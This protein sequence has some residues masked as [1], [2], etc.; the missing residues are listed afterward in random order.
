MAHRVV[1]IGGG[2][3][4]LY[5]AKALKRADVELTLIDQRN[6]H[7]F[8]PLL[9]QVA[10]GELSP[11]DVAFPLRAVLSNQRNAR[12]LMSKVVGL[13]AQ[14]RNVTLSDGESVSYDSLI[15]AT[16]AK[17]HYFGNDAWATFAPGLKSIEDATG[18]RHRI[19]YA[20]E[21]AEKEPDPEKRRA[22][23]TFV[24]VGAGP[25]GV[26]LAGALGEIAN[27]TLKGDFRSIR[28]EEARILLLDGSP[29]VLTPF[30]PELS[31]KAERSLIR[32]GVRTMLNVKVVGV[33]RNGVEL[34]GARGTHRIESRTVL[35]AAGVTAAGFTKIIAEETGVQLDRG[36]RV[37]VD[38]HCNVPGHPEIFVIGDAA[39]FKGKDG[40][41]LPGV[42]PTAMQQGSYA[43]KSIKLRLRGETIGAFKYFDK[44]S[45]AVIG[46]ARGV[47]QFG[48]SL[49][50]SGI[51]AWLLWL[52]VHLMY[53]VTFQNRLVV[54]I[55]WGFNYTTYNRGARLITGDADPEDQIEAVKQ[56]EHAEVRNS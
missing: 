14:N 33:D 19:L 15:V 2:F 25:T 21:A 34:Q 16:G 39:L 26:E 54:F 46:R 53:L 50:F 29:R 30:D 47:A 13:D 1:I 3:G 56:K 49:Q 45:L 11:G 51:V 28:P 10:T 31:A 5:A 23:L 12:V 7:L 4:G 41:P 48:S 9:Y 44:G 37:P 35:W 32:L 24:V 20:F 17:N 52:F 42:A 22:W 38:D 8:Q 40:K 6:F 55:R 18:I 27:D 36:G 43:A